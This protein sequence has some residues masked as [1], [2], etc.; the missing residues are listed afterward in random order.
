ML[1][2]FCQMALTLKN[3]PCLYIFFALTVYNFIVWALVGLLYK[4]KE[5]NLHK[6]QAK[7]VI[8][9]QFKLNMS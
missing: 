1:T 4:P 3:F 2:K 8:L 6:Y 7:M 5:R 9:E